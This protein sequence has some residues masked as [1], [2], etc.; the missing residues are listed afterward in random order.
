MWDLDGRDKNMSLSEM[1]DMRVHQRMEVSRRQ[2]AR[3]QERS[4]GRTAI[5]GAIGLIAGLI[6]LVHVVVPGGLWAVAQAFI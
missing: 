5:L 4:A 2:A 1:I 3:Q 6:Y